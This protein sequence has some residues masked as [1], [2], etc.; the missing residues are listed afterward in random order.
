MSRR[1]GI[2]RDLAGLA[3]AVLGALATIALATLLASRADWLALG[4]LV[5][6]TLAIGVGV[7]LGRYD[8][9]AP[10]VPRARPAADPDA[11]VMEPVVRESAREPEAPPT[12]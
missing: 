6:G 7:A 4:L 2:A 12:P 3:L 10:R 9:D 5:G 8:P 11:I 1:A